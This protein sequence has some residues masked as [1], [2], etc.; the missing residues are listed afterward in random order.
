MVTS[1]PA[2][3]CRDR[4]AAALIV[5]VILLVPP[6]VRASA[7]LRRP[8]ESP[9]TFR[10]NRGFQ[11]PQ[12]KT[13]VIPPPIGRFDAASGVQAVVALPVQ[14]IVVDRGPCLDQHR[15]CPDPLRGPPVTLIF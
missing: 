5:A 11:V 3:N 6:L 4:T 13:T 9:I 8:S 7:H 14:R 15:R 1:R 12:S 10:L 2:M